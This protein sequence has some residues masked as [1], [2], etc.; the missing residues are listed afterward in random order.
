MNESSGKFVGTDSLF[1]AGTTDE[2]MSA[3]YLIGATDLN[4]GSIG[5]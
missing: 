1:V 3:A 5:P 2:D 4:F